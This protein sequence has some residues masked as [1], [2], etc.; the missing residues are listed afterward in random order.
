MNYLSHYLEKFQENALYNNNAFYAFGDKQFEEKRKRDVPYVDLG[1]GLI[2][3]ISNAKKLIK[4]LD[5]ALIEA[6]KLDVKENSPESIIHREFF[7]YESQLSG[8]VE[9]AFCALYKHRE[10]FPELFSPEIIAKEFQE[11]YSLAIKND[12]F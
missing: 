2:C 6:V 12:W 1:Q 4:D 8:D 11:A 7:N 10:L 9:N 5:E 3:P